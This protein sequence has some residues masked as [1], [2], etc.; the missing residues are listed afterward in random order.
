MTFRNPWIDPR[1]GEVRPDQLRAYLDRH[2]WHSLGPATNPL[3][4]RYER[5]PDGPTLFVPAVA[6]EGAAVQ[7][8]LEAIETLARDERRWAVDLLD[9]ILGTPRVAVN[10]TPHAGQA[11][12]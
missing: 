9:D 6:D 10:G 5:G 12:A 2:G 3:L 8:M 1:M 4:L 11:H 7:W